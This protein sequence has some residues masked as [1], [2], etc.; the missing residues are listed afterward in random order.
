MHHLLIY[1]GEIAGCA[2][3][4]EWVAEALNPS[5]HAIQKYMAASMLQPYKSEKP[6]SNTTVELQF[7][8]LG[9]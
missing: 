2:G 8:V 9:I 5:S 3:G 4:G 6:E 1:K 7:S